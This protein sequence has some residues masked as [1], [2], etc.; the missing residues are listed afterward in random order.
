MELSFS[1]P[2]KIQRG[3]KSEESSRS[4]YVS[5]SV[6]GRALETSVSESIGSGLPES[7]VS[8]TQSEYEDLVDLQARMAAQLVQG[9]LNATEV[10]KL[11]MVRWAIDRAETELYGRAID[12]LKTLA[13]LQEQLSSEIS[14][15]VRAAGQ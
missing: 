8:I 6:P 2:T 15:L 1:A 5:A 10:M 14:R 4:R 13:R 11:Q 9:Q 7:S 3:E 12:R